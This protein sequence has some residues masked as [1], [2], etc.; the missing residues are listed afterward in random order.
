M[1]D[2]VPTLV[3]TEWLAARLGEPGLRI[4]DATLAPPGSGRDARAEHRAAHLP[5]AVFFDLEAASDRESPLPHMLPPP[6]A[7][8]RYMESLG[9]GDDTRVVVYDGSGVN[10]SAP[11]LWWMLRV[12]GHGAV[13]VLDGGLPRWRAEGRPVESG[14]PA[15]AAAGEPVRFTPRVDR[16]LVRDLDA[17][18][19]I[20]AD[21][22]AQ[23]VDARSASRF[24]GREPEPRAGLRSGHVPGA[25]SLP[26]PELVGADGRL[27]PA[28]ALRRRFAEAG[29]DPERPVVATC[30]SGVT[31]CAVA[32]GLA[33]LGKDD[34]A[35]YDG[36]W[37]E[38]GGR[39]DTPVERG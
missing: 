34:V 37:T 33:V 31:A 35:V 29:I 12:F 2:T 32:F 24:A 26:Y 8:A 30:G 36:S 14:D 22:S 6:D 13:G 15:G 3:P 27:L 19:A 18:R 5:G 28:D 4:V 21:R 17:V 11:R 39:T 10:F 16:S 23:L 20:V 7:F 1:T 25:V 38:W 9:I